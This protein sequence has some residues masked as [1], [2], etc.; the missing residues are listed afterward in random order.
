MKKLLLILI[1]SIS[2]SSISKADTTDFWNIY[3]N[4][5]KIKKCHLGLN[6]VMVLKLDSIKD[7]DSVTVEYE[8]DPICANCDITLEIEVYKDKRVLQIKGKGTANPLTFKIKD[9]I[10]YYKSKNVKK[11]DVLFWNDKNR[12]QQAKFPLF[13]IKLE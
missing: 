2:F 8:S 13:F 11:F 10:G 6:Y 12:F 7:T 3:Y 1:I 9:L 5:V 4:N